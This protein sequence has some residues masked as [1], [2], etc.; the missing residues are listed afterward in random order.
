MQSGAALLAGLVVCAKCNVRML[1]SYRGSTNQLLYC[2][3]LHLANYGAPSCQRL[4]GPEL[5]QLVSRH[6]L[7]ALEPAAL[8][9]DLKAGGGDIPYALP[10]GVGV[11]IAQE[12][13]NYNST[14]PLS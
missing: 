5:D 1:V 14:T 12:T 8:G 10:G 13:R 7:A 11:G 2:C 6:V 9:L 4:A 3:T